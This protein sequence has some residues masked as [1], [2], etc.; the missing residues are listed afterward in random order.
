MSSKTNPPSWFY[1]PLGNLDMPKPWEAAKAFGERLAALPLRHDEPGFAQRESQHHRYESVKE[2]LLA[3]LEIAF[4][5][6]HWQPLRLPWELQ[7]GHEEDILIGRRRPITFL[8]PGGIYP[9]GWDESDISYGKGFSDWDLYRWLTFV[10]AHPLPPD[11][12]HLLPRY[13]SAAF[14]ALY[15]APRA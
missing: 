12:D 4:A 13:P 8:V 7:T 10:Q 11:P 9:E 2:E 3:A 14:F 6:R 1:S 5:A 15:Y